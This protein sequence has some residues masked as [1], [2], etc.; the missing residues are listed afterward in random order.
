MNICRIK[1]DANVKWQ[2]TIKLLDEIRGEVNQMGAKYVML[3]HPDQF[4]VDN[5]LR[6]QIKEKYHLDLDS[7]D[8]DIPQRFLNNYCTTRGVS[9]LDLLPIFRSD[10]SEGGLYLL[11]DTHYN[12]DGNALA[13]KMIFNFLHERHL[14]V[15]RKHETYVK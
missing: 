8:F 6:Y 4:Q 15:S 10:G 3:I 5:K 1:P 14:L 7:Y 9:C 11:R 13:A 2:E 12:Q